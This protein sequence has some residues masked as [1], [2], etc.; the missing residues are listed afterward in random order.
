ME[1][2]CEGRK[3]QLWKEEVV[4]G[5]TYKSQSNLNRENKYGVGVKTFEE[6]FSTR[7]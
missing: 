5:G 6:R 4:W 7:G 1:E 2:G 3:F